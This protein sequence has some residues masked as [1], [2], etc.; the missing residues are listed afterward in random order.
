MVKD[1]ESGF[2]NYLDILEHLSQ[3]E[4]TGLAG[5]GAAGGIAVPLVA[6]FNS[7]IVSGAELIIDL[8][9]VVEDLKNCDLVI[10]GEGCIDLQ[11][12][13]GKGPAV[14]AQAARKEGIPV[15]AIGGAVR[16]EAAP[17]FDGIFSIADGP[18]G[19]KE[20]MENAYDLTRLLASQLGKLISTFSK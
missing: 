8:L 9:G 17:L 10:T 7:K 12:C 1:L 15:I 20:A 3:K 18:I 6:F 11:T 4:L 19:L 5:G 2:V 16:E 13:Q 14:I